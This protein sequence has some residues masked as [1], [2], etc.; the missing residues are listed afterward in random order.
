MWA[1]IGSER[2]PQEI[3]EEAVKV[4]QQ[5]PFFFYLLLSFILTVL[6]VNPLLIITILITTSLEVLRYVFSHNISGSTKLCFQ[7]VIIPFS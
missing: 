3:L 4:T 1:G 2:G 7:V 5:R 6:F